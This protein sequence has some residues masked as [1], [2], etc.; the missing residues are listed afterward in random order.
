MRI[1]HVIATLD[2]AAGGPIEGVRTLFGYKNEGYEG[3]AVTLDAPDAPY[4]KGLPFPVHA[5]GL[6]TSTYGYNAKLLPWLRENL[7]NYEGVIV[8]GLWQYMGLAAMR[9][10]KGH[11]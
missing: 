11:V 9:A 2:P 6:R 1:L 3:E 4:L 5:L 8:N 10:M 7:H